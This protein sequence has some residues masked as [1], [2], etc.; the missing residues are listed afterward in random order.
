MKK[1]LIALILASLPLSSFAAIEVLDCEK[2]TDNILSFL[3]VYKEQPDLLDHE[4]TYRYSYKTIDIYKT[5]TLEESSGSVVRSFYEGRPTSTFTN[6]QVRIVPLFGKERSFIDVANNINTTFNAYECE[7]P[8][9]GADLL[10]G[11]YNMVI[12]IGDKVFHD[13][14]ILSGT[15]STYIFGYKGPLSGSLTV[16]GVFSSPLT[17]RA[18]C[19]AWSLSCNI[20]FEIVAVENGQSFK[21]LYAATIGKET[22]NIGDTVTPFLVGTATLEN[23]KFLGNFFAYKRE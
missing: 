13:E 20:S 12:K 22:D 6:E 21:V 11:R 8:Q 1:S 2:K 14:L 4:A 23:G 10:T 15:G 17:G 9:P 19:S 5:V 7:M 3:K 18:S 16:P